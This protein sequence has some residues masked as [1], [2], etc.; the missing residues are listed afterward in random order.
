MKKYYRLALIIN[1][2]SIVVA[3]LFA[4]ENA[5]LLILVVTTAVGLGCLI[6][7]ERL[8]REQFNFYE[9]ILDVIPNPLSVTD[10]DMKWTFVNRAATDPLGVKRESVLGQH[11]SNWGANI[12]NTEDCGVNCLRNGKQV[13]SFHQWGKDF[14]VDT[15]YINGLDGKKIGHVEYV[16]EVSEKVALKAVYKDV[17]D[18]SESLTAGAN[19]LTV[20]SHALTEGST[21]QA[22]SISQI[23]NSINEILSQANDN[24]ERASAASAVSSEAQQAAT[25]AAN[26]IREL[27]QAMQEINLSSEAISDIINVID[28]IAS[29][30][31]LL[32][33]N[34]SIE[35]ARAGE[36]GRGFAVVADEVR[37]LAERST[38]A[39]SESAQYIRSSVEN[40]EKGN[41]ISQKCVSALSEI[42]KHVAAI[43]NTIGE[44]DSA[45]KSQAMGL[46]QVNQGISDIDGVVHSTA[47]SAEETS[48]SAT[49]LR[50]LSIKLQ[51]QLE[52]MRKIDGLIDDATKKDVNLIE[53]KNVS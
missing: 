29:Q 48:I 4:I 23:G 33:L 40:V 3:L 10:M 16:Q 53:V 17:D 31:N 22:T 1:T 41:A 12:C 9:Q 34:A 27:E 42:V 19:D 7:M 28:D 18:I 26:E 32:A 14:R 6:K 46:S 52:N 37:K 51:A 35:A 20:A 50:E 36:M 47:A 8:A 43:S 2:V 38:T 49:E 45:S 11:C 30:T 5:N 44:I 39:A 15:F 13:T 25:M 24:A 21:Q